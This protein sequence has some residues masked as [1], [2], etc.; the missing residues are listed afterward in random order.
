MPVKKLETWKSATIQNEILLSL[1]RDRGEMLTTDLYRQLSQ[2]YLD[3]TRTDLMD[4]LF[5]LEVR[6]FVYV[7]PIKKDVMKVEIARTAKFS[8]FM[9]DEVKGFLHTQ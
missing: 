4:E 2:L 6:G 8:E 1:R 9:Q 5:R 7:I 3:F